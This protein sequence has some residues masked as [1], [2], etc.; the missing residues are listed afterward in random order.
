MCSKILREYVMHIFVFNFSCWGRR[1][2]CLCIILFWSI[3]NG[4]NDFFWKR[5]PI[6]TN[7][8]IINEFCAVIFVRDLWDQKY[9]KNFF[10]L[11]CYIDKSKKNDR[12][13]N[14][15][16][17]HIFRQHYRTV[18]MYGIQR[19]NTYTSGSIL[20]SIRSYHKYY[21]IFMNI[22]RMSSRCVWVF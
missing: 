15:P 8:C 22:P 4:R 11:V 3:C 18:L 12:Q 10:L 9:L 7:N 21:D 6:H 20:T 13:D 16:Y 5:W 1:P 2:K 14:Y 17:S 19:V